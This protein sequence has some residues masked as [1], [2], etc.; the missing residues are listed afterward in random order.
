MRTSERHS[1]IRRIKHDLDQLTH[2]GTQ[3]TLLDEAT[4]RLT[5]HRALGYPTQSSQAGT[6]GSTGT[7]DPIGRLIAA[8]I[9]DPYGKALREIDQNLKTVQR[10]LEAIV[11]LSKI[12]TIPAAYREGD[13]TPSSI[14][15][16]QS[17]QRIKDSLGRSNL[18]PSHVET[19]GLDNIDDGPLCRWCYDFARQH[20]K[21]PSTQLLEAHR[22]GKRITSAMIDRATS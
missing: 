19:H 10:Q 8:G 16:C 5:E 1:L 12:A 13:K 15:W 4:R 14:T 11:R 17:C 6:I 18:Q 2:K 21:L 22:D 7:S 20:A 9:D 3:G